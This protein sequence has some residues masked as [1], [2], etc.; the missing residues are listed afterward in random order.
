MA[1]DGVKVHQDLER[2][3]EHYVLLD[4]DG[5]RADFAGLTL[6]IQ[7]AA[8][9]G[10]QLVLQSLKATWGVAD[11]KAREKLAEKE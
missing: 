11:R 7:E 6:T 10:T 4:L 5:T 8:D 1:V 9:L 2:T 3:D